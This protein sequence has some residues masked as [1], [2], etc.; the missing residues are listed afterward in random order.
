[1]IQSRDGKQFFYAIHD[2][3]MGG[4]HYLIHAQSIDEITAKF[5]DPQFVVFSEPPK[6]SGGHFDKAFLAFTCALSIEDVEGPDLK[7]LTD[8]VMPRVIGWDVFKEKY[9]Q[10]TK[11]WMEYI[12]Y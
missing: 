12:D 8:K 5:P 1:M 9:Y 7:E 11:A 6:A 3:G 4:H 10:P 2:Y